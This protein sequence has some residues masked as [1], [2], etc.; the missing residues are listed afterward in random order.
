MIAPS[1]SSVSLSRTVFAVGASATAVSTRTRR[2]TPVGTTF[3]FKLSE[4]ARVSI[5]IGQ[6]R[7]GRRRGKRCVAPTR[8]LRRARKCTRL[9]GKG[10]L[11]RNAKQ[12]ANSVAFSG[13]IGFRPLK[14]GRYQ[15]TLTATDAAGNRSRPVLVYFRVVAR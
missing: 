5:A 9:V 2:R 14:P 12:G 7:S 1:L 8:S 6:R 13:R 4:P 11:T 3:N 15:A 10:T